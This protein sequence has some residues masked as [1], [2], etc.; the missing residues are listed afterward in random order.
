VLFDAST[1]SGAGG[2]LSFDVAADGQ[3]FVMIRTEDPSLSRQVVIVHNWFDEVKR[4]VSSSN[5]S[6]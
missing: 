1:Y 4:L 2:D 6:K 3:R 5:L